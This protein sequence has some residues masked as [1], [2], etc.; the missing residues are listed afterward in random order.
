[1]KTKSLKTAEICIF[2]FLLSL[3]V[4]MLGLHIVPR[5]FSF[6]Q[7][8]INISS[9]VF[10]VLLLLAIP[11]LLAFLVRSI[12]KNT[13]P[14]DLPSLVKESALL[15]IIAVAGIV[16]TS[17]LCGLLA[18]IVQSLSS[19][20]EISN[21]KQTINIVITV[22]TGLLVPV[23][24]GAILGYAHRDDGVFSGVRAGLVNLKHSYLKLLAVVVA[25]ILLGYGIVW[26]FR[27]GSIFFGMAD[28]LKTVIL[29][30]LG[31]AGLLVAIKI[32][33]PKKEDTKKEISPSG[34]GN[35]SEKPI[36][37]VYKR[38]ESK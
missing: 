36:A 21:V 22:F 10:G 9:V 1:M 15:L 4:T 28:I 12:R 37:H 16:A 7:H 33:S 8:R 23:L 26:M 27:P 34:K 2:S 17:F 20:A 35:D 6:G 13:A 29:S 5:G 30:I 38:T 19:G 31:A 14:K 18:V 11:V 3:S 32:C 25:E 24:L